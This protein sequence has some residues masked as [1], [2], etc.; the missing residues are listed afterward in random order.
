MNT[1][2]GNDSALTV[3][4]KSGFNGA[5][6][7]NPSICEHIDKIQCVWQKTTYIDV[8]LPPAKTAKISNRRFFIPYLPRYPTLP[9]P[10]HTD[11]PP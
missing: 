7:L 9:Y 10:R 4:A 3:T 8:I 5:S 6:M 1:K 11:P 2:T